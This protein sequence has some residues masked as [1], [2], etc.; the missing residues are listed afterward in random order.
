MIFSDSAAS[1]VTELSCFSE[2]LENNNATWVV[3]DTG[4]LG[5]KAVFEFTALSSLKRNQ[6][7]NVTLRGC[8]YA[9]LIYCIDTTFT[10]YIGPWTPVTS[11][12]KPVSSLIHLFPNP[13]SNFVQI[14]MPDKEGFVIQIVDNKGTLV[15]TE[16]I[17]GSNSQIDIHSL[18]KGEYQLI[19]LKENSLIDSKKIVKE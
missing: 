13:S 17:N 3:E 14:E 7:Y 6:P 2:L 5:K 12:S 19:F 8:S 9:D 16:S 1:K 11:I 10:F 15:G 18:D 4:S